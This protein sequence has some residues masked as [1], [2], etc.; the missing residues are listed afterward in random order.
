MAKISTGNA[1]NSGTTASC[2]L[3]QK[4]CVYVANIGDS[5]VVWGNYN[6]KYGKKGQS[7]VTSKLITKAHK[8]EKSAEKVCI[9]SLGGKIAMDKK[10]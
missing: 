4:C 10:G 6:S 7:K 3:I 9:E 1:G 2:V 8:P 5:K